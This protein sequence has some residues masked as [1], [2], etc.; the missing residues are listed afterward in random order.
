MI[1]HAP[2]PRGLC[3]SSPNR[4]WTGRERDSLTPWHD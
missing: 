4:R 1:Q 3:A 2:A